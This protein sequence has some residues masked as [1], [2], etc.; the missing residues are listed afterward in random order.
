M[1][2]NPYAPAV[3]AAHLALGYFVCERYEAAIA[4]LKRVGR[5]VANSRFILA[6]SLAMVDR[7]AEA[8]QEVETI[9]EQR[10]GYSL[11]AFAE[12]LSL[13]EGPARARYLAA[14]E[15]AGLPA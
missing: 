6:A 1:R 10:P 8:A 3:Y 14:L 9:L 4:A 7:S 5:P 12:S 15:K 2:F 11:E 13:K